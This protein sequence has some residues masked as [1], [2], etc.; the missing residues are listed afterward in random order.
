MAA[1]TVEVGRLP[2]GRAWPYLLAY[3]LAVEAAIAWRVLPG[4]PPAAET[5]RNPT[6]FR[7]WPG[8]TSSAGPKPAGVKRMVFISNSQGLTRPPNAAD[9]SY[10]G[11]IAEALAGEYAGSWEVYNWSIMRASAPEFMLLAAKAERI[12]AD[13]VL[14]VASSDTVHERWW[15]R[16][17]RDMVSDLPMLAADPRVVAACD[18]RVYRHFVDASLF[19]ESALYMLLP[20]F[21]VG[22]LPRASLELRWPTTVLPFSPSVMFSWHFWPHEMRREPRLRN[23]IGAAIE[24]QPR[25]EGGRVSRELFESFVRAAGPERRTVIFV[26]QPLA[27]SA[28]RGEREAAKRVAL[29]QMAQA[30][31]EQVPLEVWDMTHAI[32][33]AGFF[34][35]V[36]FNRRGRRLMAREMLARLRAGGHIEPRTAGE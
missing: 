24:A 22:T 27:T 26:A 5:F 9:A 14:I 18:R 2:R 7:N 4:L 36:H 3:M 20:S 11:L 31:A 25:F 34:D 28:E 17:P 13:V 32:R 1:M 23:R 12:A 30:L 21:R 10:P 29:L 8:Y 15:Q 35:H 6:W 33:D 16:R 19:T